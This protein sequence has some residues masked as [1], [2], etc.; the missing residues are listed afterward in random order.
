MLK[1]SKKYVS[2]MFLTVFWSVNAYADI[3]NTQKLL[4]PLPNGPSDN[5][6]FSSLP[7]KLN[8]DGQFIQDLRGYVVNIKDIRYIDFSVPETRLSTVNC[9]VV[10]P[11]TSEGLDANKCNSINPT[12]E[13]IF[14][15]NPIK[16]RLSFPLHPLTYWFN[17][18]RSNRLQVNSNPSDFIINTN[19][20][21]LRGSLWP[22]P[23]SE[24][25]GGVLYNEPCSK[26]FGAMVANGIMLSGPNSQE[27]DAKGQ[28]KEASDVLALFSGDIP[29][30]FFRIDQTDQLTL[31]SFLKNAKV[32]IAGSITLINNSQF[33]PSAT[34]PNERVG[35]TAI[36][37][38]GNNMVILV[39]QTGR[40][41][42]YGFSVKQVNDFLKSYYNMQTI[43]VLD[44]SGSSQL[45]S[46]HLPSF[47]RDSSIPFV[48]AANCGP[49][50]K[51]CTVPG[52]KI[53]GKDT[54]RPIPTFLSI[55]ATNQ[56]KNP[57][58]EAISA[59]VWSNELA[60]WKDASVN[61]L[62]AGDVDGDGVTDVIAFGQDKIHVFISNASKFTPYLSLSDFTTAQGWTNI[63]EYPRLVGDVNGDNKADII[64]FSKLGNNVSVSLSSGNKSNFFLQPKTWANTMIWDSYDRKPRLLGDVNG[65]GKSDLIGFDTSVSV[66]LSTGSSFSS[67]NFWLNNFGS[68]NGWVSNDASPRLVGDVNGDGKD[69]IVGFKDS[70]WVS[71]ST[72]TSFTEPKIWL[73][74]DRLKGRN[75]LNPRFL[76]DVNGDRLDDIVAFGG[77]FVSVSFSTGTNFLPTTPWI[78]GFTPSH[79]F[80]N[81]YS[82][83]RLVGDF[84]GNKLGD[85]IG[86]KGG[87]TYYSTTSVSGSAF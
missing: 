10:S 53:Q 25:N 17:E 52:D 18:I 23:P 54:V 45:V 43:I 4:Y 16:E 24:L 78:Y 3:S 74:D 9:Q 66:A 60:S 21:D 20:F 7:S 75:F 2:T 47:P 51:S 48:G 30:Q 44:G 33:Y 86:N 38:N 12:C 31:N 46:S 34:K 8:L 35:R 71:T 68:N 77:S 58:V 65:D 22:N 55:S 76:I 87:T 72:G 81:S 39:V 79:D 82:N 13:K 15:N 80:I 62:K 5:V 67:T 29:Y 59:Q 63:E 26:P 32:A 69:D 37:M 50:A 14:G 40:D 84:D 42:G 41:R 83:P 1:L 56:V 11:A 36:G 73:T 57:T 19:H 6:T 61:P 28:I 49:L 85:V 27:I 70:V 64:G